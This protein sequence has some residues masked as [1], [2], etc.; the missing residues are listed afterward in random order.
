M[1]LIQT[2]ALDKNLFLKTFCFILNQ[3]ICCQCGY[4]L[5]TKTYA[6]TD[7]VRKYTQFYIQNFANLTPGVC[8]RLYL[9]VN[10]YGHVEPISSPKSHC[11][12]LGKLD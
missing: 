8:L 5:A 4:C 6:K 12:F 10:S 1:Q 11:L 7:G 3:N 9:R 2:Q